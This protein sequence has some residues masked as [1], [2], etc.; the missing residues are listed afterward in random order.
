[1]NTIPILEESLS[2]TPITLR[3]L[4]VIFQ[5]YLVIKL[6]PHVLMEIEIDEF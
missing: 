3:L 6:N 2:S 1:M 4:Y 5:V